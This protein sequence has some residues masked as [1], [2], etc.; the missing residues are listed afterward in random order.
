[1]IVTSLHQ[2]YERGGITLMVI[3]TLSIL[4]L[5]VGLERWIATFRYRGRLQIGRDRILGHLREQNRT[6]AQA[7]N[8]SLPWHPATDLFSMLLLENRPAMS[9]L[10]RTQNRAVRSVR[11]RLWVLASI[12]AIAPFVG[13]FGTVVGV[14]EAFQQIALQGTGGF[15]VVSAGISGALIATAGG[16]FVGIEAVVLFNYL[17]VYVGEYTAVLKEAAEEILECATEVGG[18]VPSAQAR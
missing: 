3:L 4:A 2:L 8:S 13:L 15:Q 1:M 9:E 16:I 10:K 12:G 6:M 17:Q 5:A 7:V 18:A 14:M 11:R